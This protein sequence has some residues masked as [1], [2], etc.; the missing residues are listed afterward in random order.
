MKH[1][2]A[3]NCELKS[4]AFLTIVAVAFTLFL[5]LITALNTNLVREIP[6]EFNYIF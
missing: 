3:I 4:V 5:N 1:Q 2:S 6:E